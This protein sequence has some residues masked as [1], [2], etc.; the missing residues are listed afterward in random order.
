MDLTL[1][2]V[3]S[4]ANF[5]SIPTIVYNVCVLQVAIESTEDDGKKIF[6]AEQVKKKIPMTSNP[7]DK[8]VALC[9]ACF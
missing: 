4:T 2:V 9:Y 6:T 8:L 7:Q 5:N 3:N 1:A